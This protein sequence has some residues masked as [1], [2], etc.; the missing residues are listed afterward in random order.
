MGKPSLNEDCNSED[1]GIRGAVA[2]VGTH[3]LTL[4]SH[5]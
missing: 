4:S 3:F 1:S 2:A 5:H